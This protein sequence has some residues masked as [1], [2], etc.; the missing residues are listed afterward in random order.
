[1]RGSG[2]RGCGVGGVGGVGGLGGLGGRVGCWLCSPPPPPTTSPPQPTASYTHTHAV[3][4]PHCFVT[5]ETG[6]LDPSPSPSSEESASL[7]TETVALNGM[8]R[9]SFLLQ[10]AGLTTPRMTPPLPPLQ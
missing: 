8:G 3:L 10:S 4:R 1:V 9:A 6:D 7:L 2:A 5:A